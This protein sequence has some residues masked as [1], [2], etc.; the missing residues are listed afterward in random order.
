MSHSFQITNFTQYILFYLTTVPFITA[1]ATVDL[2]IAFPT[3]PSTMIVALKL[4]S[5]AF[6]I[7][8]VAK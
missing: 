4:I 5:W 2:P 8:Q 3:I 7:I 6:Y 1:V